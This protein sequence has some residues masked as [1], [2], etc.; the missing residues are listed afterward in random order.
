MSVQTTYGLIVKAVAGQLVDMYFNEVVSK[1]VEDAAG[2][3]F[4]KAVVQGTADEQVKLGIGSFGICVRELTREADSRG[5]G[6]TTKYLQ[7][8]AAAVMRQGH[9]YVELITAAAPVSPG[10][11][12][13]ALAN[14][15]IVATGTALST[16]I[17]GATFEA[18]AAAGDIVEIRLA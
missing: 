8:N 6:A 1:L 4:G 9:I 12:V 3:N 11:A 10:D 17:T 15:D 2:M 7:N 5:T 14:G 18:S 13:A 16:D